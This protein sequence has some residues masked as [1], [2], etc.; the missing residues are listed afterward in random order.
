MSDSIR[1]TIDELTRHLEEIEAEGADI[2]R[3]INSLCRRIGEPLRFTDADMSQSRTTCATLHGDE[4]VGKALATAVRLVLEARKSAKRGPAT[5]DELYEALVAGGYEFD[6]KNPEVAKHGLSTS[7]GKNSVT[8][9][10][11]PSGKIGLAEW[12]GKEGRSRAN[13]GRKA[14]TKVEAGT[15]DFD[16]E[17]RERAAGEPEQADIED[18]L[19]GL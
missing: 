15:E 13:G 16:M 6:S 3:T 12:Y 2:K 18:A 4:Y 11:L 5:L 9:Y 7:V 1:Q 10:R 19:A 14:S 8:F 17:E